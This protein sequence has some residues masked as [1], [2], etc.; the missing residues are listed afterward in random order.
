MYGTDKTMLSVSLAY[1]LF[2]DLFGDFVVVFGL[3]VRVNY[4]TAAP[5]VAG[6]GAAATELRAG[7][8]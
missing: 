6:A 3:A 8:F 7:G 2:K 5:V 1:H 4:P